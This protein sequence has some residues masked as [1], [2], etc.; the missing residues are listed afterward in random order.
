MERPSGLTAPIV[1][2]CDGDN[3]HK[4]IRREEILNEENTPRSKENG[5]M[6]L[7]Y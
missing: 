3:P 4:K 1:N 5:A 7:S 2:R 6:S